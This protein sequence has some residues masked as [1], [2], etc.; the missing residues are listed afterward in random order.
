[1]TTPTTTRRGFFGMIAAALA[2]RARKPQP[3]DGGRVYITEVAEWPS[4]GGISESTSVGRSSYLRGE[5]AS[6]EEMPN[7]REA[8]EGSIFYRGDGR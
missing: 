8:A 1:M 7:L 5:G 3:T 4:P 6:L 2:A